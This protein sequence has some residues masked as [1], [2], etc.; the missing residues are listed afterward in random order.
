[1]GAIQETKKED[2]SFRKRANMLSDIQSMIID[3]KK[4][5]QYSNLIGS[6]GE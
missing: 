2:K 5:S 1:M 4:K 6:G 3:Y